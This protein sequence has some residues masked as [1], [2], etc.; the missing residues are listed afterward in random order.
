M[1]IAASPRSSEFEGSCQSIDN[2]LDIADFQLEGTMGA[3]KTKDNVQSRTQAL[4]R[5]LF[6]EYFGSLVQ[7]INSMAVR[8]VSSI[9]ILRSMLEAV[10]LEA[11]R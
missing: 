5:E 2:S 9:A 1:R 10:V 3:G 7:C 6:L 4:E 11:D 8:P